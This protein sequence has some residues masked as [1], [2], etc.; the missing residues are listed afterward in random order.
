MNKDPESLSCFAMS[1]VTPVW[2]EEVAHGY[3]EDESSKALLESL[4]LGKTD[5]Q[6]TLQNGLIRFKGRIWIGNNALLQNKVMH[7]PK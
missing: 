1:I 5:T 2:L 4:L 6:F 7:A 3:Q